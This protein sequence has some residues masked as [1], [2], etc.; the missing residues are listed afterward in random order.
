MTTSS[1]TCRPAR[2]D[3]ARMLD[4]LADLPIRYRWLI[5]LQS[6]SEYDGE[7]QD[8]A[9]EKL[10]PLLARAGR[11]GIGRVDPLAPVW[12][13]DPCVLEAIAH[14]HSLGKRVDG[15]T[16]GASYE[17]LNG[18]AAGG[19]DACHEAITKQEVLDRLRLGFWTILRHSSLRPDIPELARAIT[20]DGIDTRRV[21]LT[22]D[23]PA[24]RSIAEGGFIDEAL[25]QCVAAGVPPVEAI[26]MA[27]INPATYYGLDRELGGIAPGRR[28]DVVM[29]PDLQSFRPVRVMME[30]RDVARDGR[31]TVDLPRVDWDAFGLR[32]TFS[33]R[34]LPLEVR[35]PLP[36][37]EFVSNAI[38]RSAGMQ[39]SP[40][41][42]DI[43]GILADREG[44]WA[45]RAWIRNFAPGLDGLASSYNTAMHLLVLGRDRAGDAARRGGGS[46]VRRRNCV[47]RRLEGRAADRRDDDGCAVCRDGACAGGIRRAG[48]R[49]GLSVPR[50]SLFAAVPL[51][52]FPARAAAHTAR[53]AGREVRGDRL[54]GTADVRTGTGQEA[55]STQTNL[56]LPGTGTSPGSIFMS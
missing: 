7:A 46:G 1:S 48:A 2:T 22:V 17:K 10:K 31:A 23:G 5:R 18:V 49:G 40:A 20:E 51:L 12:K 29:L 41:D 38:T 27:T 25:R 33:A 39:A 43:L 32:R 56:Y 28:A 21:M 8:F 35:E 3:F 52:R 11:G 45:T 16:A 53:C 47:R 15:H 13:G 50:H 9:L 42:G 4:A 6:Q 26:Q 14:V 37:I 34:D 36:V 19:I 55:C 54:P 44:R 24:P 30:G